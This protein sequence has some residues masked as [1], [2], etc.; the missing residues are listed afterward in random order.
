M[1]SKAKITLSVTVALM[2]IFLASTVYLLTN[3]DKCDTEEPADGNPVVFRTN[4]E[5]YE[6]GEIVSFVLL[7]NGTDG[8]EYDTEI[9]DTLQV[10]D[11]GG[12]IVLMRP[13]MQTG[14]ETVIQPGLNLSG[15][16]NQTYYL[17]VWEEG[18]TEP[19]WDYRSWT[20][21]TSEPQMGVWQV[22]L[23]LP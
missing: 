2:F 1:N 23:L 8:L 14:G 13:Y 15:T 18:K 22:G 21:V 5:V 20:Q 3:P 12:D 16:W 6:P 19:T 17:Y 7:N 10:F 4:K 11:S 9:M